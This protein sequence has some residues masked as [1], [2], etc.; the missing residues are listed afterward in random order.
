MVRARRQDR[1]GLV[2][3]FVGDDWAE[4]HHDVEIQDAS[5]RVLARARLPEGVAGITRLHAMIGARLGEDDGP[6]EVSIGIETDRGPWVQALVAAG[7]RVYPI[8]PRQ[9]AR[10]R[11]R[12]SHSGAKSDPGDAHMLADAVRTDRHQLRRAAGDSGQVEAVKLV[13]RAHQT[14]VWERSRHVAR[15]RSALRESFPAALAAFDD[16]AA[17]DALELL[18][19]APDPASAAG[20][21]QERIAAALRRAR[22]KGVAGKAAAIAAALRAEQLG[23]PEPLVAAYAAVVRSQVAVIAALD[24]QVKK[25]EKEVGAHFGRHR[26]AEIY[27]SQPGF[28]VVTGA[29]ALGEFGDDP[30]RYADARSRKNYAGTSPITRSAGKKKTV[31]ARFVHNDRLVDALRAQAFSALS[32]SAGA[33]GYYDAL[34]ARGIENEPALR[35]LGNRLVGILHGCLKTRTCYDEAT[36]WGHHARQPDQAAPQPGARRGGEASPP[37]EPSLP[38]AS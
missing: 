17:P 2:E 26:D 12:H 36:A 13:A 11:E 20:L 1:E 4:D 23:Q 27:R 25:M 32:T 30:G 21:S 34:R 29:R 5:G 14:L 19:E 15:L 8:N 9:A 35:Q 22:R 28:G 6:G 31:H 37:A 18:A 33:R 24:T 38:K 3:L 10:F 16:L 7:Y